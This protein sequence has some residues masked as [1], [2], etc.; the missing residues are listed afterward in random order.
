[1]L[2]DQTGQI[3]P[4]GMGP[5]A[6]C[7]LWEEECT[8]VFHVHVYPENIQVSRKE[9]GNMINVSPLVV[10]NDKLRTAT[11]EAE[12]TKFIVQDGPWN[13]RGVW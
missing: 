4:P 9:D 1:V 3:C 11:I 6:T 2:D 13:L 5:R 12:V 7:T 10:L 8:L